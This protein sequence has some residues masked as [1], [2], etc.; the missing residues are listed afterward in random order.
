MRSNLDTIEWLAKA[1]KLQRLVHNPMRYAFGI[2][3][4]TLIYPFTKKGKLVKTKTFFGTTMKVMLPSGMDL[5]LLGGK[6]HDSEIRLARFIL[7]TLDK[8]DT[9]LDV[10]AHYGYFSLMASALVQDE[11][12]VISIEASQSTYSILRQN[13]DDPKNIDAFHIAISDQRK[14]LKFYEYPLIYSEYNSLNA[15]QYE[16]SK[17]AKNI[18]PNV[19][20]VEAY[21]LDEFVHEK[22]LVP[23]F[24][25]IDVEGVEDQ[26]IAGMAKILTAD[27]SPI[28]AMEYIKNDQDDSPHD[29]A[30]SLLTHYGYQCHGIQTN[31]SLQPIRK[32]ELKSYLSSTQLE[33]DNIIF[34]K[35]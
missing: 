31:G 24:I 35:K 22:K 21:R 14:T 34:I 7:N 19:I 9:F 27:Q 13:V 16:N 1:S 28:V 12:K 8:G 33:S 25:K 4:R 6:S 30:V 18:E 3:H 20:E 15:D 10:G 29:R 23:D 32:A 26:V 5:F 11:G 2:L 17:W